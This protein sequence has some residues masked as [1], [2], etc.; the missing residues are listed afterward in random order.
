MIRVRYR[1]S[2]ELSPGLHAA[3]EQRGR[4][5]TVYLLSGLTAAQRRSA[6]RRLRLTARMG[7]CPRLPAGQ[8]AFALFVDR[9]RTGLGRTGAVLRLH[10]AG[11]TVPIM[12]LSG[13]AIAFLL[14]S[15]VSI[16]VLRPPQTADQSAAGTSPVASASAIPLAGGS[17]GKAAGRSPAPGD[18]G[19]PADPGS[20]NRGSET[21]QLTQPSRASAATSPVLAAGG[22]VAGGTI[23]GS[24]GSGGAGSGGAG[25]G[26]AGSGGAGPGGGSGAG[27]GSAKGSGS[28]GGGTTLT[29]SASQ[30]SATSGPTTP[31]TSAPAPAS[32]ASPAPAPAGSGSGSSSG[33][34][35]GV[36]VDVGPLGLCLNI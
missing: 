22:T 20:V 33:T 3:A 7:H 1:G 4:R 23:A 15:T 35:N 16:H 5:T 8:L 18:P 36:C 19:G 34:S 13:G 14:F 9:I 10:P 6:L 21:R 28:A 30:S 31:A 11:S 25:S 24:A 12:V 2:N 32:A 29:G 17:Q 26:S 27:R